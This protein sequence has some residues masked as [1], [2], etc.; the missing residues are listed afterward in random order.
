MDSYFSFDAA[1][2]ARLRARDDNTFNHFYEYFYIPIRNRVRRSVPNQDADDL[3]QEVFAA[4]I[5]QI[6]AG[7]PRE[8]QKLPG[9]VFGICRNM[10][11]QEWDQKAKNKSAAASTELSRLADLQA[12]IEARLIRS[13]DVDLVQFVLQRLANSY[14]EAINREFV[15]EQDRQTAAR[16]METTT[17]NY[18]LILCRAL[19]RFREEWAKYSDDFPKRDETIHTRKGQH[20]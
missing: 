9:Y 20:Q 18:R 4:V 3:V 6:D 13:L 2:L 19:K 17:S 12:T 7:Q 11:F 10:T 14:R 8:P 15:L 16:A 1:Y 5:I